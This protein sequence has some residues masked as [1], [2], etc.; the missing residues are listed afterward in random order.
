MKRTR[1]MAVWAGLAIDYLGFLE[2]QFRQ[3][4]ELL[5]TLARSLSLTEYS[6]GQFMMK[7]RPVVIILFVVSLV[8]SES[9]LAQDLSSKGRVMSWVPPYATEA[10]RKNLDL[11]FD[12]VGV[13]DGLTH[14]GL[15][16]WVPT[17]DGRLRFVDRF[18]TIDDATVSSFQKWGEANGVKAML[19]VYNTSAKGWDWELARSAFGKH[20]ER[21]VEALVSQTLRLK[22]D[23]V[24]IDFEG[25]GSLDGDREAFVKFIKELS[26]R[27]HA[28]GKELTI[29]TFAYKWHAPNQ[30]W[31]LELLPHI[32]GLH[33]MGYS[34]TGVGAADWRS[35]EFIKAAAGDHFA[36]VLLGVSSN[37]AKWQGKPALEHLAWIKSDVSVGLAIWDLQ[38]KEPVWRSKGMWQVIG[39]IK[40]GAEE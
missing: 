17:E 23:G 33:V 25:K 5:S 31:W 21:L 15:Q 12:G 6:T 16:F 35:Y 22:L 18:K 20:R 39:R 1:K 19:C 37:A 26:K 34:E 40:R 3:P 32:D 29:D 38:F 2:P 10:C 27:L 9:G 24:D 7:L 4:L 28:E 11:S 13:K 30:G 14:L 36:K 8:L